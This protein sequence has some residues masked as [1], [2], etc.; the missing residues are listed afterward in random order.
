MIVVTV[1]VIGDSPFLDGD[2]ID[3]PFLFLG[4]FQESGLKHSASVHDIFFYFAQNP[5]NSFPVIFFSIFLFDFSNLF[6]SKILLKSYI[7]LVSL[8]GF[9]SVVV[10]GVGMFFG[11][12]VLYK[13][14]IAEL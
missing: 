9:H 5:I 14:F 1:D 11:F 8:K 10:F 12:D 6:I 2:F 13:V 3:E 4:L 7:K